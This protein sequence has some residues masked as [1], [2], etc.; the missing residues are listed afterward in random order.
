MKLHIW[1]FS[2][3]PVVLDFWL[4][5]RNCA[6]LHSISF[7]WSC[8]MLLRT[9]FWWRVFYEL[10]VKLWSC[11]CYS[12]RI[13]E[14][15]DEPVYDFYYSC[16]QLVINNLLTYVH[17]ELASR[18]VSIVNVLC[19][20]KWAGIQVHLPLPLAPT[21]VVCIAS[22]VLLASY[23]LLWSSTFCRRAADAPR[24]FLWVWL[25]TDA[26]RTLL[27]VSHDGRTAHSSECDSQRTHRTLFSECDSQRTH[28]EFFS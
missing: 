23:R 19:T 26:P 14:N 12:G 21:E 10:T 15:K 11:W 17:S 25:T 13:Y 28:R 20:T 3:A 16:T 24:T 7:A 6:V 5:L 18:A 27:W 1:V 22:L 4:Q 9:A 2:N 8:T